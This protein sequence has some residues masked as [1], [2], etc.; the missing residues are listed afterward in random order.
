MEYRLLMMG[1][2]LRSHWNKGEATAAIA[3]GKWDTIVLQEQ[4]TL[5]IKNASRMRENVLLFDEAIRAAEAED[6][7][8]GYNLGAGRT[9]PEKQAAITHAYE[10]IGSE[11]GRSWAPVGIASAA[12]G[13][14][15]RT[16]V[17]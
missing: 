9:S 12:Y 17:A 14:H 16:G 4:S 6:W 1:A 15:F 7:C 11:I 5:P 10:S 8:C 13:L 2:S 3:S